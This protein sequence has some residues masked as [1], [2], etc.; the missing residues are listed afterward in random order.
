VVVVVE[1]RLRESCLRPLFQS[2]AWCSYFHMKISFHS[3]ANVGHLVAIIQSS[4]N[5]I[6]VLLDMYGVRRLAFDITAY[7]TNQ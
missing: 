2:E 1:E 5:L 7:T 4:L 6:A 3:H